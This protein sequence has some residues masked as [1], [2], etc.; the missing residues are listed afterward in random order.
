MNL[1]NIILMVPV[2]LAVTDARIESSNSVEN[3][4]KRPRHSGRLLGRPGVNFINILHAPFSYKSALHSFS[5]ITV[6][7]CNFLAQEYWRKSCP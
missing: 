2:I 1:I 6:W 5:I 4:R 3:G 7:L